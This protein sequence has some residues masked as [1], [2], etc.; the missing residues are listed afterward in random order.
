MTDRHYDEAFNDG[1][2]HAALFLQRK[3]DRL[4]KPAEEFGAPTANMMAR[5]FEEQA[6]EILALRRGL[7]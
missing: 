2:E 3:A 5:V 6:T 7:K 4:S 1:L